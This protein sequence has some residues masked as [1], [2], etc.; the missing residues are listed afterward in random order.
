MVGV[1]AFEGKSALDAPVR[2]GERLSSLDTLRGFAVLGIFVMNIYGFGH[3]WAA[4]FNPAL[5]VEMTPANQGVW[6]FTDIFVEG[7]MR[8]LFSVLFGAGVI[9]FTMPRAGD[10]APG[11]D[12]AIRGRYFRRNL[13]LIAFG[14]IHGYLLLWPGEILF[15]YGVAALVLWFARRWRPRT[16]MTVAAVLFVLG[17]AFFGSQFF[18]FGKLQGAVA[19]IEAVQAEAPEGYDP[20]TAETTV[21]G[22]DA[23]V[24]DSFAAF[25]EFMAPPPEKLA[26]EIAKRQGGYLDNFEVLAKHRNDLLTGGGLL[27]FMID[28]LMMM[29]LGMAL[30]RMGVLSG[31]SGRGVYLAMLIVGY[32]LGL[33]LNA[34]EA[35]GR[36]SAHFDPAVSGYFWT[37]H[38]G[39]L[40]VAFGHIGLIMT[41]WKAGVF[42]PLWAGLAAA[43]RMALTNYVGQ[44]VIAIFVF[45]GVGLGLVG[46][47]DFPALM[48]VVAAVGLAQVL[49]S[50]VWLKVFQFGPLEWLWRSLTYGRLQPLLRPA[51]G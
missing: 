48:G 11:R 28:A 23:E 47:L 27:S 1:T 44:S 34:W 31:R 42:R 33:P 7:T 12:A 21:L 37:Y 14:L 41:L 4:F 19:A 46:R 39:R 16:L 40:L 5:A 45:T 6:L 35:T 38:L 24:M 43:G 49:L 32:G 8:S 51:T 17:S 20:A 22:S 18:L 30:F 50:V 3:V 29:L 25:Q 36:L 9:L 15:F 26:E 10:V 2:P 13:W